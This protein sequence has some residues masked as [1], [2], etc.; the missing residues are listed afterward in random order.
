MAVTPLAGAEFMAV[1]GE[2]MADTPA[3]FKPTASAPKPTAAEDEGSGSDVD[4]VDEGPDE[5]DR[6]RAGGKA[7]VWEASWVLGRP[8][9]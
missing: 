1:H 9:M 5:V 6:V 2:R 3:P 7:S 8:G 4:I